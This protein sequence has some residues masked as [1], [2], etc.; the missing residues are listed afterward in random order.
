MEVK[1]SGVVL[2]VIDRL[3]ENASYDVSHGASWQIAPAV[4]LV[5]SRCWIG[6]DG[7]GMVKPTC[8]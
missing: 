3:Y 2:H 1:D 4:A 8:T 6:N 7:L 5:G